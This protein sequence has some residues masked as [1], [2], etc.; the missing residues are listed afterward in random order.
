M[1]ININEF[2]STEFQFKSEEDKNKFFVTIIVLLLLVVIFA[3][4]HSKKA[5][6][7]EANGVKTILK[8]G[9]LKL[10]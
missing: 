8:F 1:N 7:Q 3:F 4:L 10:R 5:N 9:I 6:T 2:K